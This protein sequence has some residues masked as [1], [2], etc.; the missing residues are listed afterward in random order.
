M[1]FSLMSLKSPALKKFLLNAGF[2]ESEILRL[3]NEEFKNLIQELAS[4][5]GSNFDEI[6][7]NLEAQYKQ[8]GLNLDD[9]KSSNNQSYTTNYEFISPEDF[10]RKDIRV[11]KSDNDILEERNMRSTTQLAKKRLNIVKSL[12]VEDE[13]KYA[14]TVNQLYNN[15]PKPPISGI[16]LSVILHDGQRIHRIFEREDKVESVYIW[17]AA[18][19]SVI[20]DQVKLG[21]FI[22]IDINGNEKDPEQTIGKLVKQNRELWFLRII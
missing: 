21:Y 19:R 18:N 8:S 12:I 14:E 2:S 4:A 7:S 22:L 5:H 17:I 3:P 20:K 16:K 11:V 10:I 1:S 9:L 6:K 15:L 13:K